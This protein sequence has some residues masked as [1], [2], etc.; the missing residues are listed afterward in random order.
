MVEVMRCTDPGDSEDMALTQDM[1]FM[2]LSE[3]AEVMI[4]D[5]NY[6]A[7]CVTGRNCFTCLGK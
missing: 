5:L 7:D 1:F 2:E 6:K 4:L 3:Y